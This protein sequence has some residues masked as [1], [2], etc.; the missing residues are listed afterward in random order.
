MIYL[1]LSS[2]GIEAQLWSLSSFGACLL[3]LVVPLFAFGSSQRRWSCW[4]KTLWQTVTHVYLLVLISAD[5]PVHLFS[6]WP[7]LI[8]FLAL[9]H[10]CD[11]VQHIHQISDFC[12][13][14]LQWKDSSS[15]DLLHLLFCVIAPMSANQGM[16]SMINFSRIC[17][18]VLLCHLLF[19][20]F[21]ILI[22]FSCKLI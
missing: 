21:L 19:P 16:L 10:R 3:F 14:F 18:A 5:S 20:T 12:P 9:I 4:T 7:D 2:S 6:V 1:F 15:Y 8:S 22:L 13:S 17:F 11:L